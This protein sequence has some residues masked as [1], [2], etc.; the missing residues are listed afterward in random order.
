[1]NYSFN[2]NPIDKVQGCSFL[3]NYK[4]AVC[5]YFIILIKPL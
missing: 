2:I 4:K 5:Y 3:K 1:M